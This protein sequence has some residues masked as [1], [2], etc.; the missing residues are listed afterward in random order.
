MTKKT[1]KAVTKLPVPITTEYVEKKISKIPTRIV[2]ISPEFIPECKRLGDACYDVRAN[3]SDLNGYFLYIGSLET[4]LVDLGFKLELPFGWEAQI[5]CRSGWAT[6][7]LMVT[8]GIGTID[9][10]FRE[11]LKVILTNTSDMPIIIRHKDRIAQI[12]LKPVWY[13]DFCQVD[14]LDNSTDRGGGFGSTGIQ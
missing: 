10:N 4:K 2:A 13:F 1:A 12:T 7:G 3:L 8:N 6:K 11:N 9:C 14:T 5:R